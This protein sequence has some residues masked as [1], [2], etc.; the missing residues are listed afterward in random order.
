MVL[1]LILYCFWADI[2]IAIAVIDAAADFVFATKRLVLVTIA[3]FSAGFFFI[4]LWF[5]GFINILSINDVKT[6]Q[7]ENGNYEKELLWSDKTSTLTAFMIIGIFWIVSFLREQ[8]MFINM[9]CSVEFYYTSN[10]EK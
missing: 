10:E 8:N 9:Y 3:S 1:N 7:N 5:F 6:I 4:V 2:R